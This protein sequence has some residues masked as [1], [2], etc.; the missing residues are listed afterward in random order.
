MGHQVIIREKSWHHQACALNIGEGGA[1]LCGA[2]RLRSMYMSLFQ[3]STML[4]TQGSPCRV[5]V[6]H[7]YA[8]S[9]EVSFTIDDSRP[10]MHYE[11]WRCNS[12]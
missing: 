2:Q 9:S 11:N 5:V 8:N 10:I 4:R 1:G 3:S 7:L 12:I 6:Q